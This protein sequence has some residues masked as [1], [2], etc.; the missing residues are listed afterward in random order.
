MLFSQQKQLEHNTSVDNFTDSGAYTGLA[1][2][3]YL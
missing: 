2:L 3:E 1:F